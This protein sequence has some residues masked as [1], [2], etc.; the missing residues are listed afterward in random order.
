MGGVTA[1]DWGTQRFRSMGC[2]IPE[3]RRAACWGRDPRSAG[4][5]GPSNSGGAGE[6]PNGIK[7]LRAFSYL[8]RSSISPTSLPRRGGFVNPHPTPTLDRAVRR[9]NGDSPPT[10][11]NH[12]PR[13]NR[14]L[15]RPCGIPPRRRF[16][17]PP[18]HRLN[19]N[20]YHSRPRRR[21][22]PGGV[23]VATGHPP[24]THLDTYKFFLWAL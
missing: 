13:H 12:P 11:T 16:R 18:R 23:G 7:H 6:K 21:H 9:S 19:K 3:P 10:H 17:Q 4:G 5:G 24:G 15:N 1:W 2:G 20:D 14:P 8:L 22:R